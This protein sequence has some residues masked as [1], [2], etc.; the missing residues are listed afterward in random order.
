MKKILI[1]DE[2]TSALDMKTENKILQSIKSEFPHLTL[3]IIS[4]R[5]EGLKTCDQIFELQ[6]SKLKTIK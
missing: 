2:A 3:I 5:P 4:H 1:L 6:N